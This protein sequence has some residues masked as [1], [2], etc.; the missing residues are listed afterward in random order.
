[1]HYIPTTNKTNKVLWRDSGQANNMLQ[2]GTGYPGP[3]DEPR[4]HPLWGGNNGLT[5]M[6]AFWNNDNDKIIAIVK[7]L[8]AVLSPDIQ[9][10]V[11]W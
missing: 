4:I 5:M 7:I 9:S 11:H 1:M 10:L 3:Y 8:A 6:G 2:V